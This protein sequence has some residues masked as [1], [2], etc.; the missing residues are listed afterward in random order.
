MSP[1]CSETELT[2]P[3]EGP[4]KDLRVSEWPQAEIAMCPPLA[5]GGS[6]YC[7]LPIHVPM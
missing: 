1:K 3:E 5:H 4:G 6:V 2:A 7:G